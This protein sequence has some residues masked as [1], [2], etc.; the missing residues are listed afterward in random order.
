MWLKY[1]S[2]SCY[3]LSADI[4]SLRPLAER[5]LLVLVN[6]F[7]GT[8]KALHLFQQHV[9]PVFA[10]ASLQYQLVVTGSILLSAC[11]FTSPPS[12]SK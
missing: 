12:V 4:A 11:I 2:A 6:P 5:R 1:G 3:Q 7:S 9:V 8:G 10:E